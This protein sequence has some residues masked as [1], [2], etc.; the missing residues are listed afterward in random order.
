MPVAYALATHFVGGNHAPIF[1]AFGSFALLA[2]VD[3][4]GRTP[5]RVA[6]YLGLAAAG[7]ILITIGT[8][9]SGFL[10]LSTLTA[11]AITFAISFAGVINGYFAAARI[12]AVLLIV[13][14]IMVPA[15]ANAIDDRLLGWAIACA[16]A[17]PAIFLIWREPWARPL[18]KG[19]AKACNALADLVRSPD[20]GQLLK[21]AV[22][23]V[24]RLR[25]QF[26]KTPHRPTGATGSAAAVAALIE[27]LSWIVSIFWRPGASIAEGG[28]EEA[29]VRQACAN[30]L[31]GTAEQVVKRRGVVS[32][33]EIEQSREALI[34]AFADRVDAA[35]DIPSK[36]KE[37]L[38]R[39]FRLRLLSFS[40]AEAAS[41][42]NVAS[43]EV[44]APGALGERWHRIVSRS[45]TK[46]AA[47]GHLLVE[48]ASPRS[49]WLRNSLRGAVGIG[50]AIFAADLFDAQNA[51]W[52]VLGT[53][54]V[55]RSNA[56]GTEGTAVRALLGTAVGIAIG[57]LVLLAIGDARALLWVALPMAVFGAAYAPRALS[58]AAGQAAFSI[59]VMVLFNL[60]DPVGLE[61]GLIR[62]QDVA[63]GCGVSLVVGLLMWPRGAKALIRRCLGEAYEVGSRLVSDR[64]RSAVK[65]DLPDL[66]D[67]V[68]LE[69][70]AAR[71]RLDVALRQYLEES[72]GDRQ[73]ASSFVALTA[74]SARLLRSAHGL[75]MMVAMPWYLAPPDDLAPVVE[76]VNDR[77][78]NWYEG[79]ARAI[80]ESGELPEAEEVDDSFTAEVVEVIDRAREGDGDVYATL[81]GAWLVQNLEYLMA[82]E[83]R[84]AFHAHRLFAH[85]DREAV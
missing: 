9:C 2:M 28:E 55:L 11:G 21:D 79:L 37:D 35:D 83:G 18:R 49:A 17:I 44:Q 31:R 24:I 45:R 54:S 8:L 50:L 76:R 25:Q 66:S 41:I 72:S 61:V 3:F 12:A 67:P 52:V 20:D 46:A 62:V 56:V 78:R 30:V 84:V 27:E 77:V 33:D 51:F 47:T 4:S 26:F 16:L 40:V 7:A 74:C 5:A 82:L 19:C 36:L 48:H 58:F 73:E 85:V 80:A 23:A 13:L 59:L 69:A 71:E 6:A 43:G 14:P 32:T 38:G 10:L 75:R 29:A 81:S 1:A 63:I 57:G 42:G 70:S 64:V 15:D 34:A 22:D 39:T 60:I 53:L 65:G 68:R